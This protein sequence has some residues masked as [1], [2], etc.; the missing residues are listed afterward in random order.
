MTK[1]GYAYSTRA[2]NEQ[3]T[4]TMIRSVVDSGYWLATFI[5]NAF[6]ES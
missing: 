5:S 1:C 4:T 2:I 6:K 3:K